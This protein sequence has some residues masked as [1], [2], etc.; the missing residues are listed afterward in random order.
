MSVLKKPEDLTYWDDC[1]SLDCSLGAWLLPRLKYFK[2]HKPGIPGGMSEEEWDSILDDMIYFFDRLVT[3]DDV[4]GFE[5]PRYEKG[6]AAFE[7]WW[8]ALWF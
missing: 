7:E 2:E 5:D 1:F 6:Q 3:H 8:R 4:H